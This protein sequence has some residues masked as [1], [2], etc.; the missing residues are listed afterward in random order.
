MV[1]LEDGSVILCDL[2]T[3]MKGPPEQTLTEAGRKFVLS[4]GYDITDSSVKLVLGDNNLVCLQGIDGTTYAIWFHFEKEPKRTPGE[5][6]RFSEAEPTTLGDG[7]PHVSNF[8]CKFFPN[9]MLV[10]GVVFTATKTEDEGTK[11]ACINF[12]VLQYNRETNQVKLVCDEFFDIDDVFLS[13]LPCWETR[14]TGIYLNFGMCKDRIFCVAEIIQKKFALQ[15][16]CYYRNKFHL[17][18][19]TNCGRAGI[20]VMERN[21]NVHRHICSIFS[22]DPPELKELYLWKGKVEYDFKQRLATVKFCELAPR[23]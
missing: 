4:D 20:Y 9:N 19:G 21:T 13:Q 7:L 11:P 18:G 22:N 5:I 8:W 17:I 14:G 2:P 16:F 3:V 23:F 6:F 1:V 12:M 10:M 15:V